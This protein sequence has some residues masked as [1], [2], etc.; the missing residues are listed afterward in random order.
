MLAAPCDDLGALRY[1]LLATPKIDGIRCLIIDGVA[2]SRS[3]KPIPNRFIQSVIGKPEFNGLDGELLVGTTFQD[4]TSGIM[5][6]DGQPDFRYYVFDMW[7]NA[8]RP[9]EYKHRVASFMT[10]LGNLGDTPAT[11]RIVPLL[12]KHLNTRAELDTY[13][14]EMLAEGH[15][16]IMVRSPDGPYKHGRATFK[17]GYLTKI[18]PF[19]DAE[20]TVVGF[21]ERMHNANEAKTNALGRTERSSHKENLVPM[22]TLGALVVKNE[23]LWPGK[24]FNI[25]TGFTDAQRAELWAQAGHP[26]PRASGRPPMATLDD[27]S[28]IRPGHPPAPPPGPPLI[29]R[30]V[31]FKYQA[32]GTKDVPRIPVF[33]G[34]RDARDMS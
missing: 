33:L 11:R 13:C 25:G 24:T 14:A 10:Q 12:P 22:G 1:P 9:G 19:E 7:R 23:K 4:A 18:K 17:E 27:G 29:G 5:S 30:T 2:M 21:E 16:G 34:F 26:Q 32:I 3:L 8:D 15:E 20:A 6:E 28:R 31:K